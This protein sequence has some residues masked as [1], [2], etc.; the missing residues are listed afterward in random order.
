[1][2]EIQVLGLSKVDQ[3]RQEVAELSEVPRANNQQAMQYATALLAS[4]PRVPHPNDPDAAKAYRRQL[5]ESL[6]GVEIEILDGLVN[7]RGQFLRK[8]VHPPAI[9]EVAQFVEDHMAPKLSAIG[10]KLDQI[11]AIEERDAEAALPEE[12]R[13]RRADMLRKCA[14]V[15]RETAKKVQ[16][17]R[18][19]L[20][21]N[22][23]TEE[24]VAPLRMEA[25]KNLNAMRTGD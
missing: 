4:I 21:A 6:V 11:T 3:L 22:Q 20:R 12:E 10:S 25:L 23:A 18:P 16:R 5:T 17:A 7:P 14:S 24:Q 13:A 2:Q 19:P 8:Q 1:M 9:A 15:I